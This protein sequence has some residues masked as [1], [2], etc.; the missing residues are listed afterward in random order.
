MGRAWWVLGL[1]VWFGGC[2]E[3]PCSVGQRRCLDQQRQTCVEGPGG[4]AR[5]ERDPCPQDST[6][7]GEGRCG[8]LPLLPCDP[9]GA[10]ERCDASNRIPGTCTEGV[11]LYDLDRACRQP[12]ETCL[13]GL[14]QTGEK[15]VP[16]AL[17][18]LDPPSLCSPGT[19][20][21]FCHNDLAATCSPVGYLVLVQDCRALGTS[22]RQGACVP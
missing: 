5:W 13:T 12:G 21:G 4:D 22:C 20:G 1:A 2:G 18:V 9:A 6:C 16:R 17:C 15:P 19:S 14:D 3:D 7:L 11:W 10:T 8:A